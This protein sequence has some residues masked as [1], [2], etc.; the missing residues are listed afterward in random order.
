MNLK[1]S[2]VFLFNELYSSSCIDMIF[3]LSFKESETLI[4][5]H[6]YMTF[7]VLEYS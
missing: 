2:R 1:T 7:S 6:I 3:R 5:D 4:V